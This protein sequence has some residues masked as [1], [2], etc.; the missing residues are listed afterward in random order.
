MSRGTN[1]I[2]E[3]KEEQIVSSIID[4]IRNRII[5]DEIELYTLAL[6]GSQDI[7]CICGDIDIL[8][9]IG[10]AEVDCE[11]I[12][13]RYDLLTNSL[14]AVQDSFLAEDVM[15]SMV[16]SFR[17]EEMTRIILVTSRIKAR[18]VMIHLLVYPTLADLLSWEA[19]QISLSL[20]KSA[21]IIAG[22]KSCFL[23]AIKGLEKKVS[24]M[25]LRERIDMLRSL[26]FETYRFLR[27]SGLSED[28]LVSEGFHKIQY[29]TKYLSCEILIDVDVNPS[30]ILEWDDIV[31]YLDSLPEVLR[32]IFNELHRLR[33]VNQH[34][35]LI[36]LI[37]IC[38][39]LIVLVERFHNDLEN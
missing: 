37:E 28:I 24:S 34:P 39:D 14:K 38:Y 18:I 3:V 33:K 25:P 19:P 22:D 26:L 32:D 4:A 29:V 15:V 8:V 17:I 35:S 23:D 1:S 7:K 30:S 12:I 16:P 21:R 2:S 6:V 9:I 20:L 36:R 11:R 10:S 13:E 5:R 27:L 31:N